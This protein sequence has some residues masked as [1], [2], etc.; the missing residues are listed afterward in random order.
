[1]LFRVGCY[2][3][4]HLHCQP[5]IK[6]RCLAEDFGYSSFSFTFIWKKQANKQH[7]KK[8]TQNQPNKQDLNFLCE[9]GNRFCFGGF[10]PC[11]GG[12]DS[13]CLQGQVEWGLSPTAPTSLPPVWEPTTLPRWFCTFTPLQLQTASK[14]PTNAGLHR[15][16]PKASQNPPDCP[17]G[18]A[19]DDV[20]ASAPLLGWFPSWRTG[21]RAIC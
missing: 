16:Q 19:G 18:I 3:R 12:Q 14:H 5:E 1:M 21:P 15:A 11:T 13:H 7:N 8:Q 20:P 2:H 4:F 10:I 6:P 17:T 9:R